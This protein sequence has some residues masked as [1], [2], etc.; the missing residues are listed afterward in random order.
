MKKPSVAK[1]YMQKCRGAEINVSCMDCLKDFYGE[2]YDEHTRC[3][4]EEEKYSGKDYVPKENQNAGQKKQD[5]WMEIVRAILNSK[6]YKLSSSVR[7]AFH[8]LQSYD[9][10]PR[11][12]AKFQNFVRNCL[13]MDQRDAQKVWEILSQELDKFKQANIKAKV[14]QK[15]N[16]EETNGAVEKDNQEVQE[17]DTKEKKKSKKDNKEVQEAVEEESIK[18][19]K[20]SKKGKENGQVQE[21]ANEEDTKEKKYNKEVQEAVEERSIK[22]KKKSKKGKKE[23]QEVVEQEIIKEKSDNKEVTIDD[24]GEETVT[25]N[26]KS[27]K[28]KADEEE[29]VKEVKK[30]KQSEDDEVISVKARFSSLKF[31]WSAVIL[32][33]VYKKEQIALEKLRKKV[34]KK[35]LSHSNIEETSDKQERKINKTFTKYLKK[36]NLNISDEIVKLVQ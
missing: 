7:A 29:E 21:A 19:K 8:K 24:A 10:V 34:V 11:K 23:V 4:S 28:R 33:S 16:K 18:E 27:K 2:E 6:D 17:E 36:C 35:Y 32:E 1:H 30:S 22:E 25:D 9:N 5:S 12:Q 3:I 20:K 26:K 31:D 13:R 14:E 15:A